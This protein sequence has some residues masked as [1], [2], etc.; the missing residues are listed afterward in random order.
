MGSLLKFWP[1]IKQAKPGSRIAFAALLLW[2]FS[3]P[4]SMVQQ[5]RFT[6]IFLFSILGGFLIHV[7]MEHFQVFRLPLSVLKKLFPLVFLAMLPL[8]FVA[9]H[10]D[11]KREFILYLPFLVIP[12]IVM[13]LKPEFPQNLS[14]LV[15]LVLFAA[16]FL[17][18]LSFLLKGPVTIW[19]YMRSLEENG[20]IRLLIGRPQMGLLT[21]LVFFAS[22]HLFAMGYAR[23][24]TFF[25]AILLILF[26]LLSKMA[27]LAILLSS[28]FVL[29]LQ[30]IRKPWAFMLVLFLFSVL[31]ITGFKILATSGIVT[32]LMGKGGLSFKKYPK[33]YVNSI[34]SRVVLWRASYDVFTENHNWI[35]GLPSEKLT[36]E[37]N[38]AIACY[39]GYLA[40]KNF[41][42]HNQFLYLI[43]HYGLPGLCFFIWFWA[44]IF[45]I[46]RKSASLIGLWLFFFI[47]SQTEIY[48]DREFGVQILMLMVIL[49]ILL[50]DQKQPQ[51]RLLDE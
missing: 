32:E 43:L 1:I 3:L 31:A 49:T 6:A 33:L 9:L 46:S 14:R 7:L 23:T 2:V 41:N 40:G 27:L 38:K 18:L 29:L 48:I 24:L 21:G 16:W 42:P 13:Y 30:L 36:A 8:F 26:W 5:V 50:V 47:C 35:I 28:G 15:F 34:N 39:N 12:A 4:F 37:M 17:L 19:H 51:V 22:L 44:G 45:W 25:I 11:N 20:G 10:G